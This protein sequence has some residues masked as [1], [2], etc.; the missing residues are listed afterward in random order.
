MKI[1]LINFAP[2]HTGTGKYALNIFKQLKDK[3]NIHYYYLN[4]EQKKLEMYA[5]STHKEIDIKTR[6]GF[7]RALFNTMASKHIPRD[8]DLYHLSSQDI[9]FLK[10]KPKIIT[11]HDIIRKI[12]PKNFIDMLQQNILYSGLKKAVHI[13]ADS[14]CT[15]SDLA[16]YLK[17]NPG[18]ITVAHLGVDQKIY[19]P[20]KKP[21]HMYKKYKL[22]T[23]KK[24]I[25]HISSEEPRKKYHHLLAAFA[26]IKEQFPNH[27]ILKAGNAYEKYKR[28]NDRIGQE[29]QI[30][31]KITRVQAIPEEE[32]PYFYNLAEAFVF[33][34]AYE[35][36]GLPVLEAMASGCPTIAYRTSSIPEIVENANPLV[37]EG[38]ID[39]LARELARVL[40]NKKFY[41]KLKRQGI[42]Q[43]AKFTW[44]R[45]A[46]KTLEVYK[47]CLSEAI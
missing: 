28:K 6:F 37:S 3:I 47:Q 39:A 23:S 4:F 43:A 8:Y 45:C 11:C 20:R 32:L 21:T 5:K 27:R 10:F 14:Y 13:I 9:S 46:E 19:K 12:H 31:N 36:F 34:S 35:G 7:R 33:P 42:R 41:T 29:L 25:L 17:I 1:A 40:K 15:K 38:D 26:Q 16:V 24:Y 2:H 22:D 44:Q 30:Q 18:K